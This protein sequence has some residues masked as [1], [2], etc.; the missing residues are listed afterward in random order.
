MRQWY[1][2]DVTR[3]RGG[4]PFPGV[5]RIDAAWQPMATPHYHVDVDSSDQCALAVQVFSIFDSAGAGDSEH[6]D[7]KLSTSCA[8]WAAACMRAVCSK[9]ARSAML[10]LHP[11]S[12]VLLYASYPCPAGARVRCSLCRLCVCMCVYDTY[13]EDIPEARTR[14]SKPQ[15]HDSGSLERLVDLEYL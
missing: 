2:Y 8:R 4:G 11:L 14:T 9:R 12:C 7:E 3:F 1:A 5:T 15:N 13:A 6:I 10:H